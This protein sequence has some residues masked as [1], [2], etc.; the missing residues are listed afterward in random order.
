MGTRSVLTFVLIDF[1]LVA[2]ILA[3]L[4]SGFVQDTRDRW[5]FGAHAGSNM[6]FDDYNKRLVGEGGRSV[7]TAVPCCCSDKSDWVGL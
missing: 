5:A 6:W 7:R 3:P 2:I 4:D 1:V